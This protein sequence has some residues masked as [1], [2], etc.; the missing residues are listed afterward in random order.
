M[1][2]CSISLRR[3]EATSKAKVDAIQQERSIIALTTD[4]WTSEA[5]DG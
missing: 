3:S 2:D 1:I 4:M 5:N